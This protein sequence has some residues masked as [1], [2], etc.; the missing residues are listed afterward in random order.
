M[1]M[2]W[3]ISI[4]SW[5]LSRLCGNLLMLV[6][7]SLNSTN[8]RS[9]LF[10]QYKLYVVKVLFS[11]GKGTSKVRRNFRSQWLL[12]IPSWIFSN[13]WTWLW[14]TSKKKTSTDGVVIMIFGGFFHYFC[15]KKGLFKG[16]CIIFVNYI[17]HEEILFLNQ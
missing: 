9:I 17:N 15:I 8:I 13:V 7:V 10:I 14:S 4:S 11:E 3:E 5:F 16:K 12:A 2:Q 6:G 1:L